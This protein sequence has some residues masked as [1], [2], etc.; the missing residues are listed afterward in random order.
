MLYIPKIDD[1]TK[2]FTDEEVEDFIA[3]N[4]SEYCKSIKEEQ[5]L[6][7][8]ATLLHIILAALDEVKNMHN[9]SL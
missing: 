9:Q 5:D 4:V 3:I 2:V 8:V 6:G 1:Y 7:K